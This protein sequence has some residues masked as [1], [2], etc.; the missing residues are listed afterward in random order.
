MP[1]FKFLEAFLGSTGALLCVLLTLRKGARWFYIN[2]CYFLP[3][4]LEY[5]VHWLKSY[6][7]TVLRF[8]HFILHWCRML[9]GLKYSY[10][11]DK[12]NVHL[13]HFTEFSR[14]INDTTWSSF[15]E[16]F[17]FSIQIFLWQFVIGAKKYCVTLKSRWR[18]LFGELNFFFSVVSVVDPCTLLPCLNNGECIS[19]ASGGFSCQCTPQYEGT[20]CELPGENMYQTNVTSLCT[21]LYTNFEKKNLASHSSCC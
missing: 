12:V 19:D 13:T 21:K 15:F 17:K 4:A 10:V 2:L 18:L 9:D 14:N 6:G 1:L 7:P 8:I 11:L 3:V 16:I 20:T 5:E